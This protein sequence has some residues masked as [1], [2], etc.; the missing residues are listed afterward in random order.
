M[1]IWARL[2]LIDEYDMSLTHEFLQL[3]S[4]PDFSIIYVKATRTVGLNGKVE[5]E[6]R[7]TSDL[8]TAQAIIGEVEDSEDA[9]LSSEGYKYCVLVMETRNT[10]RKK[11]DMSLTYRFLD[12]RNVPQSG[13]VFVQIEQTVGSKQGNIE[14]Y[15]IRTVKDLESLQKK[16]Q[17]RGIIKDQEANE[18]S[19][20]LKWCVLRLIEVQN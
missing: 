1:S 12:L 6:I 19:E 20:G 14:E 16:I 2:G 10:P 7:A 13:Y 8:V 3:Q 15:R 5:F 9:Q 4:V 11:Y 17:N 18:A